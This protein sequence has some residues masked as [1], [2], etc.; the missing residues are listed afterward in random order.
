MSLSP[1]SC[2]R[3]P[4]RC[5]HTK[6]RAPEEEK[7]QRKSGWKCLGRYEKPGGTRM[8]HWGK[9]AP[10]SVWERSD[11]INTLLTQQA[12]LRQ[13][14]QPR[15]SGI[16]PGTRG[17]SGD[18]RA[19]NSFGHLLASFPRGLSP[20]RSHVCHRGGT[21]APPAAGSP[22]PALSSILCPCF[23][24]SG[25]GFNIFPAQ[26]GLHLVSRLGGLPDACGGTE[27]PRLHGMGNLTSIQGP[28]CGGCRNIWRTP[29][30]SHPSQT[31]PAS[32]PNALR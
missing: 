15:D 27:H 19:G 32:H 11:A 10:A 5:L 1:Q 7:L 23:M 16:S 14:K 22:I 3:T 18:S 8:I 13:H 17:A 26:E 4:G 12:G 30:P 29:V 6:H 9:D 20:V 25:G 28:L 21:A 31:A 2:L 24:K